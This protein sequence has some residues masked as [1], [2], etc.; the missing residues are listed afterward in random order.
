MLWQLSCES[1][2][3]AAPV[4]DSDRFDYLGLS[5]GHLAGRGAC[6]AAALSRT[7]ITYRIDAVTH[8]GGRPSRA[9]VVGRHGVA[10]DRCDLGQRVPTFEALSRAGQCNFIHRV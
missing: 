2:R 6:A 10:Y 8:F 3:R 7:S 5:I 1:D 4:D 9:L